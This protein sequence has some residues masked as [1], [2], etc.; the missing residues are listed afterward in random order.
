[1][2]SAEPAQPRHLV[3]GEQRRPEGGEH[4][5]IEAMVGAIRPH[6]RGWIHLGTVPLTLAAGIVLVALAPPG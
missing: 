3:E 4:P 1:M 2:T 6:L 5:H